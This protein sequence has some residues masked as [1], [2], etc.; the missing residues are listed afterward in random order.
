MEVYQQQER[1]IVGQAMEDQLPV[2]HRLLAAAGRLLDDGG[3]RPGVTDRRYRL[4]RD[5][6]AVFQRFAAARNRANDNG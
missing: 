3:A 4:R 5:Q 2:E 6:R 1:G